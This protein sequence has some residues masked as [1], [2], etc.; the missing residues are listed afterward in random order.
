MLTFDEIVAPTPYIKECATSIINKSKNIEEVIY[1]SFKAMEF[2]KYWMGNNV[3]PQTPKELEISKKGD[4]N[5]MSYY[6]YSLLNEIK[7]NADGKFGEFQVNFVELLNNSGKSLSHY[8]L[9]LTAPSSHLSKYKVDS[10]DGKATIFLDPSRGLDGI[11]VKY[12]DKLLRIL[13]N[14][15]EVVAGYYRD[16]ADTLLFYGGEVDLRGKI[17]FEEAIKL[18]KLSYILDRNSPVTLISL[19]KICHLKYKENAAEKLAKKALFLA[20]GWKKAYKQLLNIYYDTGKLDKAKECLKKI[21]EMDPN[22]PYAKLYKDLLSK[23][24]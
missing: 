17:K 22:D 7:K 10:K 6:L 24:K 23:S 14:E 20:P 12:N 15:R 2:I 3:F 4:C 8:L 18:L 16:A 21:I 11:G 9:S 13:K 5:E 1:N 19:S